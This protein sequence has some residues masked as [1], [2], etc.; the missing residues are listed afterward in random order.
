MNAR[1]LRNVSKI[2]IPKDQIDFGIDFLRYAGSKGCEGLFLLVGEIDGSAFHVT[3]CLIPRQSAYKTQSGVCVVLDEDELRKLN[4]Y[5]FKN[6]VRLLAQAHS[7]PGAAYH[8]EMD[9]EFAIPNEVGT[10]SFVV[11]DFARNGFEIN[12]IAGYRLSESGEWVEQDE[13]TLSKLITVSE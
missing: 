6:N 12:R 7:H 8:S 3:E 4:L 10:F 11:P 2:F 9:D 1:E 13:A 5:L